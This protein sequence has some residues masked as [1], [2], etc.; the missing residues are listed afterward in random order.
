MIRYRSAPRTC[1]AA[2]CTH[3]LRMGRIFC[4]AHWYVLPE[5]LRARILRT[6]R[7][8]QWSF[9]Q[10]A[11]RQASDL[12]DADTLEARNGG[13]QGVAGIVQPDGTVARFKWKVV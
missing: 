13:F 6:F 2:T 10:E 7:N 5:L 9:H 1:A 3:Q 12:I 11:I 4:R 8:K